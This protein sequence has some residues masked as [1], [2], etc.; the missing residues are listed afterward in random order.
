MNASTPSMRAADSSDDSELSFHASGFVVQVQ[1]SWTNSDLARFQHFLKLRQLEPS[2]AQLTEVLERARRKYLAVAQE[3]SIC[4]ERPC[5]SRSKLDSSEKALDQLSREDGVALG[6]T[7]CQGICKQAPVASLR[8]GGR[9]QIFSQVVSRRDW[10]AVLTFAKA[11]ERA[12]SLLVPA[13]EAEGLFYDPEHA[14]RQLAAQLKPLKFLLGRF[15]GEGRYSGSSYTFEKELI[16]TYEAGGRFIALRMDASY[17][18]PDG[19][20]DVHRALV[21]VGAEPSSGALKGRAFTDGGT[22]HDYD[23]ER[24]EQT[25][26]FADAPPDHAEQWVRA[27]K[28]LRPTHDGFEECLE[29][30]AGHGF[31]LYYAIAMRRFDARTPG[32]LHGL[33]RE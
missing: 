20:K 21:V 28:T 8:A 17:P 25:L 33:T 18:T 2:P 14:H 16:G 15:R 11:T 24:N 9:S 4:A 3:L 12:N 13:G 7:G 10:A 26:N 5:R 30:D 23:V 32:D 6:R 27:R 19:R 29:V 31:R 22:T 1:G